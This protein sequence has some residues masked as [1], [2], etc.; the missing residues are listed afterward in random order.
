MIA[1]GLKKTKT[2]IN[3]K[4]LKLSQNSNNKKV[5]VTKLFNQEND[6]FGVKIFP[7]RKIRSHSLF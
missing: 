4:T 6:S 3:G 7:P 5:S 1:T 2:A